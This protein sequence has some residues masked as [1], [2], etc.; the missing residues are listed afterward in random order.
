MRS[1]FAFGRFEYDDAQAKLL[2]AGREVPLTARELHLLVIF[3]SRPGEWLAEAWLESGLWPKAVPPTGELDRLVRA[4]T[5]ALDQGADGVATIQAVK[6]RGYRLLIPVRPLAAVRA[7]ATA[8]AAMPARPPR[9]ASGEGSGE[10]PALDATLAAGAGGR[11]AHRAAVS[12]GQL[13]VGLLVVAGA[14]LALLWWMGP[15]QRAGGNASALAPA[16]PDAAAMRAAAA[17]ELDKGLAAAPFYDLASRRAAISHFEAALQLDPGARNQATAHAA[18]A[19][20]LVLEDEMERARREAQAAL[21]ANIALGQGANLAEPLAALAFTQLFLGR[22]PIAARASAERALAIDALHVGARRALVW[23]CAVEGRFDDALRELAPASPPGQFDPEV[24]TDEA[25]ILHLSGRSL[26]A[27]QVLATVL[28]REPLF[29]RAHAALAAVHLAD[30]RLAAA[31]VEFEVLDALSAGAG[32][33][34]EDD[35]RRQVREA[36]SSALPDAS[37]AARLLAERAAGAGPDSPRPASA[38]SETDAARIYAQ[39][40]QSALALAALSRALERRESAATLARVDPAFASLRGNAAFRK[41]LD[42][43][44]VPALVKPMPGR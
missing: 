17:A 29:R 5:A 39:F 37:E 7:A 19:G 14:V 21:A 42:D 27:R 30:R 20:L 43:A 15:P 35:A 34:R 41:R 23:V 2:L 22:D 1:G 4:L 26:E 12:R 11:S 38:G 24:A 44:G 16:A 32:A 13:A 8:A 9:S 25:W 31:A 28:R 3:L 18:L 36:D 40:G 10:R 33:G 6:K